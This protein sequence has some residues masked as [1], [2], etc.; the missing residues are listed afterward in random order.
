M[1]EEGR[2]SIAWSIGILP[3]VIT[4]YDRKARAVDSGIRPLLLAGSICRLCRPGA[5][6]KLESWKRPSRTF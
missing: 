5:S 2:G 4:E 1:M 3:E 6:I